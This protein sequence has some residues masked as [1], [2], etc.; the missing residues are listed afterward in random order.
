MNVRVLNN[1]LTRVHHNERKA[2]IKVRRH[3]F[4]EWDKLQV[5]L[6]Y[7]HEVPKPTLVKLAFN[8]IVLFLGMIARGVGAIRFNVQVKLES[9]EDL[10]LVI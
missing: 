5:Y 4:L 3:V 6:Q 7:T 8:H 1:P 9:D 10:V 2:I